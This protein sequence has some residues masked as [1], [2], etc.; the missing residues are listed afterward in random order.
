MPVTKTDNKII[1]QIAGMATQV[2]QLH[3]EQFNF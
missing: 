3:Q 2:E 1:R